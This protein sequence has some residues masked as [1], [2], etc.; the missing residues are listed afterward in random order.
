MHSPYYIIY[1]ATKVQVDYFKIRYTTLLGEEFGWSPILICI[2][3][4][5]YVFL[6]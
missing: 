2:F 4:C 6:N 5:V 3:V 1:A